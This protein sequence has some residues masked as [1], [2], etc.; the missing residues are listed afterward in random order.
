MRIFKQFYTLYYVCNV[1][2]NIIESCNLISEMKGEKLN[3]FEMQTIV[4]IKTSNPYMDSKIK[5]RWIVCTFELFRNLIETFDFL[6][7][8]H[9]DLPTVM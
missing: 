2:E 8:S 7:H 3:L 1:D 9:A 4:L 5:H 6:I